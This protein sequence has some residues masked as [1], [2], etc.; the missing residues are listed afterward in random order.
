MKTFNRILT[1]VTLILIAAAIIFNI[2]LP[3]ARQDE[4]RR[5]EERASLEARVLAAVEA[6]GEASSEDL[7]AV[8]G[9]QDTR[10][11]RGLLNGL[12][13]EGKV[14]SRRVRTDGTPA[15]RFDGAL[16]TTWLYASK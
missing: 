9:V 6:A 13:R 1:T 5:A 11:A 16:G 8:E 7:L 14:A 3:A 10:H 4:A 12:E 15:R 2:V